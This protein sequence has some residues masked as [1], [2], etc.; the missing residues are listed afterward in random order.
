MT[1][2]HVAK[3]AGVSRT[4]VSKV[5]NGAENVTPQTVRRVHEAMRQV[6]YVPQPRGR[7]PGRPRA[8]GS[9]GG[10]TAAMLRTGSV[11]L[12]LVGRS[13]EE[14][15]QTPFNASFLSGMDLAL[16]AEHVNLVVAQLLDL[17]A[18]PP[19]VRARGVD[20][21]V[22]TARDPDREVVDSLAPLPCVWAMGSLAHNTFVDQVLPNNKAIGTMAAEYLMQSG[23]R[24]LAFVDHDVTHA[25]FRDRERA[26]CE[27]ALAGG[28]SVRSFLA[29]TTGCDASS[30]AEAWRPERLRREM[31]A[32]VDRLLTW[33]PRPDG[34]FVPSDAQTAI[35]YQLL[36][37]RGVRPGGP[38]EGGQ[39]RVVSCN[40][41][42]P[43]LATMHPRPAVIDPDPV[44]LGRLA[45]RQLMYRIEHPADPPVC[46]LLAPRLVPA[47]GGVV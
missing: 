14:L 11:G 45:V 1:T 37:E 13:S 22:V 21:L 26:Y 38:S 46:L 24:H 40:N 4:T 10:K 15:L 29:E 17:S 8:N 43:L 28:A 3:V 31:G 12:L 41:E 2:A 19:A 30:D 16:Q 32:L 9:N 18:P 39:M 6:G 33:S 5:I 27:A 36:A 20:G 7:G 44:G 35:V 25:A 47:G 23:C 34:L 42:Q